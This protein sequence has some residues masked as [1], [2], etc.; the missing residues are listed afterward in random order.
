LVDT[1][2]IPGIIEP[3]QRERDTKM[4]Y[5]VQELALQYAEKLTAY[6]EAVNSDVCDK[7]RVVRVATNEMY[8]AQNALAYACER[9]AEL[10]A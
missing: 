4:N 7:A 1:Y 9:A 3:Y 8:D 6:Y 10:L 2:R 5:T